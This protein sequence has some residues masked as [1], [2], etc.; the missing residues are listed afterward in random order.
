MTRKRAVPRKNEGRGIE[1]CVEV[2][3]LCKLIIVRRI[4]VSLRC[5][6]TFAYG[7]FFLLEISDR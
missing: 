6:S 2:M 1:S 4:S 7:P 5:V 3:L